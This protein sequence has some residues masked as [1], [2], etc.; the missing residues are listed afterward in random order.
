MQDADCISEFAD[1][2]RSPDG[3][4]DIRHSP[5]NE[6]LAATEVHAEDSDETQP[7]RDVA[8]REQKVEP[9][10]HRQKRREIGAMRQGKEQ[11]RGHRIEHQGERDADPH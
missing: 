9:R 1:R 10:L 7:I 11:R 5:R 4:P 3:D 2:R 8:G 6:R